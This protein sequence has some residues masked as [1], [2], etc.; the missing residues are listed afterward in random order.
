MSLV[1]KNTNVTPCHY[2][3]CKSCYCKDVFH[4]FTLSICQYVE[5]WVFQRSPHSNKVLLK[6]RFFFLIVLKALITWIIRFL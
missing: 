5:A 1:L 2:R 4:E 6:K 3:I